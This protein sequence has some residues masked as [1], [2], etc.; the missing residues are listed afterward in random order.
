M[1]RYHLSGIVVKTFS[2]LVVVLLM[3]FFGLMLVLSGV[4]PQ[5]VLAQSGSEGVITQTTFIDFGAACSIPTN[6]SVSSANGGELRLVASVEDYFDGSTIDSSRWL[7]GTVYS[8]YTVPPSV[9]NGV[10]TLDSAYLRSQIGFNQT[11]PVRFFE[12]RALQ[13]VNDNNAGWPDLGFYRELPPLAYGSGPFPNDSA[14]RIFVTRDSN[15]IFI[16]GRDGDETAPL[17]DLDIPTIN[18]QQYHDFRI[19]WDSSQTRFYIDGNLQGTIP[20]VS[21]L[22][23]WVFLYQQTPTTFGA[24]PMQ[25]DW[26]R[27]GT[28]PA[29]GVYVSCVQDAGQIVSWRGFSAV[30]DTPVNTG[31]SF[32]TRTS[33][34]G[35]TWSDW[36]PVNN[37]VIASPAGQYLQYR[38]ELSTTNVIQSPEVQQVSLS[39]Q[40]GTPAALRF[41]GHGSDDIDRVKIPLDPQ[42]P[43]DVDGDFTL[44]FWLKANLTENNSSGCVPGDTNWVNG[45]IIFDRDIFG[46]GDY[47]EYGISLAGGQIAFGISQ[48]NTAQTICSTTNVADGQWHHVAVTRHSSTGQM[49]IY[50][51]G[52][53]TA[54]GIGPTGSLSYRDGRLTNYPNSDPYLVIG[55]EKHDAGSQYPSYNGLIDEVRLSNVIRYNTNFTLPVA[56]FVSDGSTMALYHFDEGVIGPCTGF[57]LDSSAASGGPSHGLCRYG[58]SDPSGPVYTADIPFLGG[59]STPTPTA[60]VTPTPTATVVVSTDT[61]TPTPTPTDTPMPTSAPT[62]TPT[63][64]SAPT[65]TPT[66]TPTSVAAAN[67]ALSFD[68]VDDV[69]VAGQVPD[70]VGLT[71][72]AW[73]QP[74][75]NNEDG[76]LIIQANDNSGWSLEMNNG[77]LSFWIATNQGWQSNQH[78]TILQAGEWYHVAATYGSGTIRTFVNGISSAATSV[79]TPSQGPSLRLGGLTGYSY[80][81]GLIDEVRVSNLVRYTGNFTLPEAPFV[82]DAGTMVLWHFDEGSGQVVTDVSALANN[83]WL[84]SS[85]TADSADP[86]WVTGYPFPAGVP[87]S[88]PTNTPL[89]P[90]NTP[91]PPTATDTPI[92]PTATATPIPPTATDTPVPT[93]TPTATNTP[94]P[95][96]DTPTPTDTPVPPTNTPTATPTFIPTPLP[97]LIFADGFETGNLSAWSA[98]TTDGGD[99]SVTTAAALIGANG[100][101]AVLDDNISIYVTDDSPS[102]EPSYRVR[103]YFDPNT[104]TMAN[105]NAH[106]LFY[107]YTGTSIVVTRVEFRRSSGVYQLRAALRNDGSTFTNTSWFTISDAPHYVELDWRASTGPGANNGGLTLWID[108]TQQANLTGIDNDTRRIDRV[109]LGAVAGVD[110]GTRGTYYFDAFES[111]RQSYIGPA[112]GL[113]TATPTPT[114]TPTNTPT[115]TATNTPIPP[116]NTP[117][118]TNTPVPPTDTPT[119]TNTPVP[120]ADTPTATDTPVPPTPTPTN[121]PVPAGNFALSFDGLNDVVRAGQIPNSAALTIEAWVRPGVSN[122]TG[123]VIVHG[124]DYTGWSLELDSGRATLWL[125]TNQGWR[126]AQ[127]STVLQAGQWYHVAATYSSG[128]AQLFVNGIASTAVSVGT[129]T[130][131]PAL[132][133]GGLAGYPYFNGII[134]EVRISNVARYNANFSVPTSPYAVDANTVRLWRFDEGNGQVTADVSGSGNSGTLGAASG[135]DTADPTWVAGYPFS[136]QLG[137]LSLGVAPQSTNYSL[138]F[139]GHGVN[140]IDRV[141]IPIDPHVPADVGGGTGDFTLEF[142]MKADS[143]NNSGSCSPGND[144]WITGNTIFDRD[145][146]GNGDYGDYGVSLHGGKIAFGVNNGSSGAGICSTVSVN[147]G[148]WHHVAVTRNGSTGE[149]RIFIDGVQRGQGS[150]PTGNL[151]YRDGRVTNG[152]VN[153]PY[154]VIG[155]EKHDIGSL[156]PSYRGWI[157]EVR[158]SNSIRYTT[159]FT[160]PSTPFTPDGNT[161]ALYHFDEGPAG[162]CTGT[163]LDSSGAVGGPSNG[164]CKF[165]GAAP[166][167]PVYSTDVP[168]FSDTIP[169]AISDVSGAALDTVAVI[170]WTTDEPATSRVEYGVGS[171]TISTIETTNHVTSHQVV[172][173]GL[174]TQTTYVFRVHSRDAAGNLASNPSG[175]GTHSFTTLAAEDIQRTYLPLI[176]KE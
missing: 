3:F 53:Q 151:S 172:L 75:A 39:Y 141:K 63:P 98:N 81:N 109:Q 54:E 94:M 50:V 138:R 127:H 34:D 124:D 150:G 131:G 79:G 152:N 175:P 16:R 121:T 128:T 48:N 174:N 159:D 117:T 23:T 165:G 83:A 33:V 71:V 51:D 111:R 105:G 40:T 8:W 82:T 18:L 74:A 162:A 4:Q 21:T 99:L 62:D 113:P 157:D 112:D 125:L 87:T 137:Q 102:A 135:V 35:L 80:F 108:G 85:S 69:V 1:F 22:N 147:D 27:A 91:V 86:V 29:N 130:Q 166:S 26:V 164:V 36:A 20:G 5:L 96:T 169:P 176:I 24:S 168:S 41:Y 52:Q 158:L 93:D 56:P 17:I 101:Q 89:P 88:T 100:L 78:S 90:T 114:N 167:G 115:P 148:Q 64:T 7:T 42:V 73:V 12:A 129:L 19:E 95:P 161:F 119:A 126:S 10:L 45:N 144:N 30:L 13:R 170:T 25:V 118:P 9:S 77:R 55:A 57:V 155:A 2:G 84:G 153:D 67:F 171:P 107:G 72:E 160:P 59:G 143:G 156:Y 133:I 11:T 68:G 31:V 70:T 146:F 134:D 116:T 32:S 28:Y 110:S 173:T 104:I 103:F 140:D 46:P 154:L 76:L 65:D 49:Q 145:V 47:G 132:Q 6:V 15:T 142:W 163:V 122:T 38:A 139:Y 97:D 106:F 61:P 149:L 120:P 123:L 92:P 60:T 43:A 14:L 37:Q 66:P 58:G 136:G 44:E